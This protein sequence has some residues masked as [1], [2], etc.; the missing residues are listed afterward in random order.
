MSESSG[1]CSIWSHGIE[2]HPVTSRAG[3]EVPAFTIGDLPYG[4]HALTMFKQAMAGEP[5]SST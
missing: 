3:H 4:E 2:T 5:I 1:T